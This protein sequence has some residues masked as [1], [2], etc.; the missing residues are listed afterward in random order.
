MSIPMSDLT[1][2]NC[3]TALRGKKVDEETVTELDRILTA[4]EYSRYSKAGESESPAGL[5]K[6]TVDLIRKLENLLS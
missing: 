1:R 5:Y 2:E 6:R 4:C 3:Y